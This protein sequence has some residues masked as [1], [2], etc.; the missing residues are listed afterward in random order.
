VLREGDFQIT[1]PTLMWI[2]IA[3]L[4]LAALS[5]LF[6]FYMALRS[7]RIAALAGARRPLATLAADDGERIGA[8]AAQLEALVKRFEAADAQGRRAIQ[9]LGVVRYNPFED[10][11]SNQSFALA[12][13]DARGDGFVLSS[14]HSRQ[15][16]RVFLKPVVAGKPE[17]AVSTEET[18]AIRRATEGDSRS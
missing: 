18:E 12:L 7:R 15:Q 1:E 13:L 17:M 14:L 4:V 3:A 11:G 16:T 5:L 6:S 10:T 9:R 8:L 2:A